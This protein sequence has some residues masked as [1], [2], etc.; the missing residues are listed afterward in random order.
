VASFLIVGAGQAGLQLG[1]GLLDDGHDVTVVTNRT[2]EDVRNGRLLSGQTMFGAPLA[3]ER[4]LGIDLWQ[5]ECP[6]LEGKAFVLFHPGDPDPVFDFAARL[7]EPGQS[8]DQ[9]VKYPVWMDLFEQ[10]GGHLEIAQVGVPELERYAETH[11][12]VI[13]AA[14]R[15][16]GLFP[17]VPEKSPFDKPQKIVA[18]CGVHGLTPRTPWD[19]VCISIVKGCGENI[20]LPVLLP[21]GPGHLFVF[22][23]YPGGPWDNWP[24][25]NSVEEHLAH[26]KQL[27]KEYLPR[28]YERARDAEAADALANLRGGVTPVVREPVGEL[29]SGRLVLGIG[30]AVVVNDPLTAPGANSCALA[31]DAYLEAIRAH[32]DAPYDRAFME[33]T[34]YDFWN[35]D[36][37]FITEWNNKLLG[38]MPEHVVRVLRAANGVP[39]IAE[40]WVNAFN[41]RAD[42]FNWLGTP[43][44]ADAFLEQIAVAS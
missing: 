34:F 44:K 15:D 38:G 8:V 43:E 2:A 1:I 42:F 5:Q 20:I 10:R 29:P 25:G 39:E 12:L 4:K 36:M 9:R 17:K 14:G 22:Q 30:D 16:T 33:K 24:A 19:G 41:N 6:Q 32:G 35:K 40:R 13:V 26:S 3:T 37:R 11:D 21:T 7:D 28:M 31:A 23:Y 27:L 18:I